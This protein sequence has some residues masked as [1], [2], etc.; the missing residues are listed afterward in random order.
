MDGQDAG[1]E[2]DDDDDDDAAA[3]SELFLTLACF[4]NHLCMG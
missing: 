2:M 3:A 4:T 1:W